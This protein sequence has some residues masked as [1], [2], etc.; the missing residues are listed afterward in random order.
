M[1]IDISLLKELLV[2]DHLIESYL[3]NFCSEVPAQFLRMKQCFDLQQYERASIEAHGIKSLLAYLNDQ[4]AIQLA[5]SIEQN[6]NSGLS[7]LTSTA[8][9]PAFIRLENKLHEIMCGIDQLYRM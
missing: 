1:S 5:Q 2:D 6:C 7:E 4:E 3:K 8:L 9:K